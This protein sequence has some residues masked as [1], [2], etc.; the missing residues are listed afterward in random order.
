MLQDILSRR[1]VYFLAVLGL[2]LLSNPASAQKKITVTGTVSDE[3]GQPVIGAGVVVKGTTNGVS[4]DLDGHYSISVQDDATLEFSC[5]G[6][7]TIEEQVKGRTLINVV[8]RQDTNSLENSIVIGYGTQKR[9][10]ITGAIAAIDGEQIIKTKT[11]NPE[12][13]LTGRV[14]GVRVWQKTAEPGSY[15]ANLDIRGLGSPLVVIDGVPRDIADFQRLSPSDIENV[16]VLKDAAAAIYGLRGGNGVILVTTKA[17]KAG[18]VS[19]SYDGN[20][21]FQTPASLPKQMNAVNSMLLVNERNM[22]GL[23]GG[24]GEFSDDL[25]QQYRDGTLKGTDWN[26]LIVQNIA[27]QTRHDLSISGGNDKIQYYVGLGYFY[28]EGFWKGGDLNYTK[29]NVR[30][31]LTAELIDGLKFNINLAGYSD[32]QHNPYDNSASII[33]SWWRQSTIWKAYADPEETML[34]YEDL[35]LEVNSVARIDSDVSGYRRNDKKNFTLTSSLDY[36]FGTLT[37]ILQGLHAKGM[38]SYDY[39]LSQNET[40]RREYYQYAYDDATDSYLQKL[41]ADSSPSQLTKTDNTASQWLAQALLNYSRTF[42]KHQTGAMVGWE[43]QKQKA[44]GFYGFANLAFSSPYFTAATI[45]DHQIGQGDLYEYAYKSLIGRLNYSF[46]DRYLLEG[47]FRYDGSSKFY[48]GHQWGFFPSVSAGWRISQEP[49]IRNT[50]ALNFINNLKL[51]ASYGEIGDDGSANYEWA[52]GYTYPSSS[53]RPD[54][55][56]AYPAPVYYLGSWVMR[57]DPKALANEDISWYT[58]KTFNVGVDFEFWNGL[59]GGSFDYFRRHRTGLMARNTANL[60]TIVGA[61]APLENMNDDEHRGFELELTHRHH[62]GGFHYQLKGIL[63]ITRQK[64]LDWNSDTEYGNSY[65]NWLN[66][67]NY[68]RY[69]GIEWGYETAGR[70]SS[71]EDV[72]SYDIYKD[73][74]TKPGDFKYLDWNGDGEINGLDV[75]PYTYSGT[76]WMNY[77]FSID[78]NWKNWDFSVLF[79]GSALGSVA[80]GEPQLG[81]WGQHGGG[82]LEQFWDRWHP[83]TITSDI[84]DQSL[85]WVKGTYAYGGNSAFSNSDFNVQSIDYLRLK[86]IEVGY[87]LPKIPHLGDFGARIYA[88]AYNPFTWTGVKYI[89]PEHPADNYGRLYPL[90]KSYTIGLN[91]TF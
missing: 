17:G 73:N 13:M 2:C 75:H 23:E 58:N 91:I 78:G 65:Y 10:S 57:A 25:I 62:I 9:G 64:T 7:V 66:N 59:L 40:Y 20:Y 35:E 41:Y 18:K 36:D 30:S 1:I 27:P 28:Q 37:D 86:S 84:Y 67:S 51:R 53:L 15:D 88:N 87:T 26:K 43:V 63:T 3:T 14:A 34:N 32:S 80:F 21:T 47:Q 55:F 50:S 60:P 4:T 5:I 38:F 29:Y 74:A 48:P 61:T 24:V 46:D 83:S 54:G 12:N 81:I 19:V 6:M 42:G 90:N 39:T 68:H 8:L 22:G 70:Y 11:E 77:S 79:Q 76:P 44:N 49:F 72:W 85:T 56:Y 31:N 45:E 71:W 33:R 52:T 89:D 16:S 82:M 69:Q